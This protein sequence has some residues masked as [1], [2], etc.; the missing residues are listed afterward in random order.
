MEYR[1]YNTGDGRTAM[2]KMRSSRDSLSD[3]GSIAIGKTIGKFSCSMFFAQC[4]QAP[5]AAKR[6]FLIQRR[7]RPM[8]S[9][10]RLERFKRNAMVVADPECRQ[11]YCFRVG[12]PSIVAL[13]V[14][15]RVV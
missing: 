13:R 2:S 10:Q 1:S 4:S 7:D 11:C 6:S 12:R 9:M 8:P 5:N 14:R 3:P 15:A